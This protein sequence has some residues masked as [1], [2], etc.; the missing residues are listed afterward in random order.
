MAVDDVAPCAD[1]CP[2]LLCPRGA[3]ASFGWDFV[4]PLPLSTWRT[5]DGLYAHVRAHKLEAAQ[6]GLAMPPQPDVTREETD[7]LHAWTSLRP[8]APPTP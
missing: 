7:A 1:C 6:L 8:Y 3:G 5:P 2:R 4:Q